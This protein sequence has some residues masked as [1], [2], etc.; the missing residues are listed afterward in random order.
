MPGI[1]F[2]C[3][4]LIRSVLGLS[5]SYWQF[6]C[7][8]FFACEQCVGPVSFTYWQGLGLDIVLV[9]VCWPCV[10]HILARIRP[11]YCPS[12]SV[13]ALCRSHIGRD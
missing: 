7:P 1:D 3:Y 9:T 2:L 13:L 8:N 4:P 11:A 5:Y 6:V 10:V 12:D